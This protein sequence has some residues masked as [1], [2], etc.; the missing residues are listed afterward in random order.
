MRL[1]IASPLLSTTR[2]LIIGTAWSFVPT[3]ATALKRI[4]LVIASQC[5]R[6]E[7]WEMVQG[8]RSMNSAG[9]KSTRQ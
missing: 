8:L 3:E 1:W 7:K 6:D 5:V 4:D 2:Q 9:Q